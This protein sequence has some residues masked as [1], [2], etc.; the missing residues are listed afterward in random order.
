MVI[1]KDMDYFYIDYKNA[2]KD[3]QKLQLIGINTFHK[4]RNYFNDKRCY[5]L[6]LTERCF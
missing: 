2:K 3:I 6:I 1:I 5:S 4:Q